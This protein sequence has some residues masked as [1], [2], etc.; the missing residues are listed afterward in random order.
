MEK[1]I[2]DNI[3]KF[4]ESRWEKADIKVV[5][6]KEKLDYLLKKLIEESNEL[7]EDRN[8]EE[9]ADVEEVILSI[10]K[11]FGWKKEDIEKIRLE[12]KNKNGWFEEGF[13][14]KM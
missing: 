12:K 14:L 8:M 11:E 5:S 7:L 6:W 3:P 9:L 1:L 2:R 10:Y 4:V 13:I